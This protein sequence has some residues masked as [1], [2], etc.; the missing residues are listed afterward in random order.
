[1]ALAHSENDHEALASVR[2]ANALLRKE[3]LDWIKVLDRSVKVIQEV[4]EGTDKF[5]DVA[6]KEHDHELQ[7]AFNIIDDSKIFGDFRNTLDSI[8]GQYE[9][10]GTISPKQRAVVVNAAQRERNR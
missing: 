3:G 2:A 6:P 9:R 4:E 5:E 1:M 10:R 7:E 8:R